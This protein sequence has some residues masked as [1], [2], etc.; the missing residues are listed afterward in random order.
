M[1]L[2]LT[3]GWYKSSTGRQSALER[4]SEGIRKRWPPPINTGVAPHAAAAS[5]GF[6]L[7]AAACRRADTTQHTE[8]AKKN[9]PNAVRGFWAVVT[10]LLRCR[11]RTSAERQDLLARRAKRDKQR[12][13]C[14]S[15][16]VSRGSEEEHLPR[17][18][19]FGIGGA[20]VGCSLRALLAAPT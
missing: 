4:S 2:L 3:G 5:V 11:G 16:L 13:K 6:L 10:H 14:R 20:P 9:T 12:E 1:T 15:R 8:R 7:W 18:S 17:S 19:G